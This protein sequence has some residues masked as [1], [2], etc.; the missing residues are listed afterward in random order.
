[1]AAAEEY[2][3]LQEE[4]TCPVCLDLFRDPHLLACGH[5]F[6]KT[7]LDRL[8]RQGDRGRFRCPECRDSHR[9]ST[10][11]QKNFKL[12]N[13]ADDYRH[14][15][16][17]TAAASKSRELLSSSLS[18]HPVR[19]LTTVPC[20]YCPSVASAAAAAASQ[21]GGG[22]QEA[23]AAAA[24]VFAVKTC[25][26][27]EVSMCQEHVKPHLELP[28]FRDHPLI[29]PMNDLWKRKCPDHDEIYRYYC[30]DDKRC[31]CNACTIEGGHS[32]HSI[33]SLK[34]TMKALKVTLEKQLYKVER[35][36]SVAEKKLQE[37]K[38]KER[39][40]KKFMDDSEQ[41]LTRLGEDMKAKMLRFVTRL[42]ECTRAHCSTNGPLIQTNI[43]R[44]C[45][46]QDRL[47]EV[48][49][50]IEGL[51]QEND[52]FRFIEAYKTTGKQ[53]RRQLRKNM[54]YPEY[55]DMETEV[56]GLMIEEE[57][58]KF[59]EE[60]LQSHIVAAINSLCPLSSGHLS[61]D[62]QEQE[63]D[64]DEVEVVEEEEEEEEEEE[65]DD[66][67]LEEMRSEGEEEEEEE[68]EED[69]EEDEEEEEEEDDDEEEGRDRSE[70]ANVPFSPEEEDDD[71]DDDDDDEE[72]AQG[73]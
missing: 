16:R 9:C 54:F 25:L 46:D 69:E 13:I 47:Q 73:V 2:S 18:G 1:M 5:N 7:C 26:K 24:S 32:G 41:F 66:S 60:D 63:E 4:L 8:K 40:N 21:E 70:L 39:Q 36:Y 65:D 62:L 48:R 58:R 64:E 31:V 59:I 30:M 11:C 38:E 29:E 12:A 20:D 45:Q 34:N 51:V 15:R 28:A 68:D 57:M 55:V 71:D 67:S 17:A 22:E 50:G 61:S 37:Q 23:A 6:C 3:V 42:R 53:C 19:G 10:N 44:I 56:L 33:K 43:S 14:R 72:E 27:C 49:S 35:K 52:P